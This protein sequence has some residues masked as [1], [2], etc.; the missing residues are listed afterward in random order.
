MKQSMDATNCLL[1]RKLGQIY[2]D[3]SLVESCNWYF[4][5]NFQQVVNSPHFDTEL[6]I[7]D[8]EDLL[9]SKVHYTDYVTLVN[10]YDL[11][12]VIG[13]RASYNTTSK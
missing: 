10:R 8:L 9:I 6:S 1:Y 12:S 5:R 3:L 7:E 11:K 2:C 13:L 4:C